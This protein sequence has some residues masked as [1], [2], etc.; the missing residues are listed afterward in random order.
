MGIFG[1]AVEA[2]RATHAAGVVNCM[3]AVVRAWTKSFS[4]DALQDNFSTVQRSPELAPCRTPGSGR[5]PP[6]L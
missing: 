1:P 4:M 6:A 5:E 2:R 3:A